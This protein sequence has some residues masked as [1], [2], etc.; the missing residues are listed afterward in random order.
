MC[1]GKLEEREPMLS[2]GSKLGGIVSCTHMESKARERWH[3]AMGEV[4]K[5][6][7]EGVAWFLHLSKMSEGWD[8]LKEEE[9]NQKKPRRDDLENSQ[10][11]QIAKLLRQRL[12]VRK[13]CPGGKAERLAG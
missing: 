4:S 12:S 3:W 6:G 2:K 9:L 8:K 10:L 5:E 7:V 1:Y 13:A 11:T